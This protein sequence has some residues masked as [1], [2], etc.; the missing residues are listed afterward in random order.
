MESSVRIN[1]IN[2]DGYRLFRQKVGIWFWVIIAVGVLIDTGMLVL[3]WHV[4]QS[5]SEDSLEGLLF[6]FALPWIV[7]GLIAAGVTAHA[8]QSFWKQY[9]LEKG[10]TY[11]RSSGVKDER[12]LMFREGHSRFATNV[13]TGTFAELPVRFFEY[14]FT[15]GSG[16]SSRTYT[17]TVFEFRFTGSFPHVYL[18]YKQDQYG[19]Y[20]GKELHLPEGL[21]QKFHLY[22]PE[23]YEIEA[24]QIFTPDVLA[25]IQDLDWQYDLELV[26]QELIIYKKGHVNTRGELEMEFGKAA[27]LVAKLRPTLER[28]TLHTVGTNDPLLSANAFRMR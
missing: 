16:K 15:V 4:I 22:A 6:L 10:W 1:D 14:M 17:Y 18:N 24:L 21:R 25:L 20:P 23:Q 19:V 27:A 3:M 2:K 8:R 9:A 7:L 12:G 11:G 28:M 26:D 13:V 5:G